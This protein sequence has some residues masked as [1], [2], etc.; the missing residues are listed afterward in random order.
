MPKRITTQYLFEPGS[1][2]VL[3]KGSAPTAPLQG[4]VLLYAKTD[5]LMYSKDED[6][7]ET[8]L[9]GSS[10]NQSAALKIASLRG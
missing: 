10:F 8:P 5:G 2:V 9:S 3:S 4:G 7:T 6:N 1:N